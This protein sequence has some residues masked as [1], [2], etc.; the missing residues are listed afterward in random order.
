MTEAV[1]VDIVRT[2][3]GKGKPGG[4]ISSLHPVDLLAG[5]IRDLMARTDID[6]ALV[7]DVI[8]G[9]LS[10][11]GKQ[12]INIARNAVLAAGLPDTIPG[13]T[14]DRQCGSS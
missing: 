4:Q 7:E 5:T 12:S 9:A 8:I 1:L 11:A 10:Q 2:P 6:P 3:S 14:V 13:T